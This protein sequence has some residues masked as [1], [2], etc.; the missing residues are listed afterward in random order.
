MEVA[1][2]IEMNLEKA[3]FV[4][5]PFSKVLMKNIQGT[6]PKLK[7]MRAESSLVST[8]EDNVVVVKSS[9]VSVKVNME[10]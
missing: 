3:L 5:K 6:Y 1:G 9:K 4:V 7:S 8:G 10:W 2:K